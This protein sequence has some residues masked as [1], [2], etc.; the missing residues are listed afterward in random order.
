MVISS[1]TLN[2]TEK[3]VNNLRLFGGGDKAGNEALG[4]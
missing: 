4:S 3:S 1:F 2:F